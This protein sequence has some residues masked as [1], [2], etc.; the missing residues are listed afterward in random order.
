MQK[1][2]LSQTLHRRYRHRHH[3]MNRRHRRGKVELNRD[4]DIQEQ[5]GSNSRDTRSRRHRRLKVKEDRGR[6]HRRPRNH[7]TTLVEQLQDQAAELRSTTRET[8]L[9]PFVEVTIASG[10]PLMGSQDSAAWSVSTTGV[11]GTTGHAIAG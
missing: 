11:R 3:H 7:R 8:H 1:S 4:R 10:Q 6:R 5:R 2:H 9:M